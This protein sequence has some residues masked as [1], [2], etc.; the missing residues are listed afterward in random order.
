MATKKKGKSKIG[1]TK[2][3]KPRS[4]M[5]GVGSIDFAGAIA[6][7]AG[8]SAGTLLDR[9]IPD[10]ID[11]KIVAGAKLAIGVFLPM[12][13]KDAETKRVL[14]RV[15]DALVAVGTVDLLKVMGVMS[16]AEDGNDL[17]ISMNGNGDLNALNENVL[18]EDVLGGRDDLNVLNGNMDDDIE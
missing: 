17:F 4:K 15:G 5:N 10:S 9:I 6:V 2:R 3:R 11:P 1:R 18:A 14:T 16:G 13:S 12:A 8:A 7:V